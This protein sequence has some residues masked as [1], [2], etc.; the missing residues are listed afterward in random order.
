MNV[1]VTV[2]EKMWDQKGEKATI[3]KKIFALHGKNTNLPVYNLPIIVYILK[4]R[5]LRVSVKENLG[6]SG[7]FSGKRG[8]T[9]SIYGMTTYLVSKR[10]AGCL[11]IDGRMVNQNDKH[12]YSFIILGRLFVNLSNVTKRRSFMLLST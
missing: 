5:F 8:N 10:L 1:C 6:S 9:Q 4:T 7:P 2:C 11:S 3:K 12:I